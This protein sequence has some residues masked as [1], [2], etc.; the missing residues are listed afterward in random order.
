MR[1]PVL[2]IAIVG[3][4]PAAGCSILPEP[5]PAASQHLLEWTGGAERPAERTGQLQVERPV[6]YPGYDSTRML[7][8]QGDAELR[9]YARNVWA[10]RP[11]EMIG[12]AIT[13]AVA[14]GGPFAEVGAPGNPIP[15]DHRLEADLVRLDQR[16]E[17]DDN[18][19]RMSLRYRLIDRQS[20][21][22]LGSTRHDLSSEAG[23][24]PAG[25][26]AAANRLLDESLQ[27]LLDELP[28]WLEAAARE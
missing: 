14:A 22:I 20:G 28:D 21:R 9:H 3:L 18:R 27:R 26:A 16:I 4:L 1:V 24:G 5:A 12:A 19:L 25:A 7:Y 23:N 13:E 10:E 17:G 11:A 2:L 8:R 15:A 6:A